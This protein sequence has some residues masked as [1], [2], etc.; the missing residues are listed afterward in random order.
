MPI[1]VVTL[2][3]ARPEVGLTARFVS[4][5]Q[6]AESAEALSCWMNS[7]SAAGVTRR[8]RPTFTDLTSPWRM[9]LN[10]FARQIPMQSAGS[11]TVRSKRGIHSSI[12]TDSCWARYLDRILAN[13]RE[14]R[15]QLLR[16][17]RSPYR[18]SGA[19][20][21]DCGQASHHRRLSC[22]T[23]AR[24]ESRD[25]RAGRRAHAWTGQPRRAGI[26]PP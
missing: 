20:C 13:G 7:S 16:R 1:T 24:V 12:R 2:I 15:K 25:C 18:E 14:E 3:D 22:Q 21:P 10:M 26:V 5:H 19:S 17:R 23:T 9:S 8:R 11:S 4:R 6:T